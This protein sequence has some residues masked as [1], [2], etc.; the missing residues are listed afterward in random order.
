MSYV[1]LDLSKKFPAKR[2]KEPCFDL[3]GFA[4]LVLA[5]CQDE[6][7]FLGKIGRLA[8]I[9][10]Q[11]QTKP[12]KSGI[13]FRNDRLQVYLLSHYILR[14]LAMPCPWGLPKQIRPRTGAGL[15]LVA[16]PDS[17]IREPRGTMKEMRLV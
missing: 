8:L 17:A 10:R 15:V 9:S 5:L 16:L 3:V 13:G 4:Y 14:L 7:R 6:K 11:G 12:V 2:G 1:G